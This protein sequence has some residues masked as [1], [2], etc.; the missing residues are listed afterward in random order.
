MGLH[1]RYTRVFFLSFY[2]PEKITYSNTVKSTSKLRR[3]I[4]FIFYHYTRKLTFYTN[5]QK[6]I[7]SRFN[8]NDFLTFI[9]SYN[10][11]PIKSNFSMHAVV[12]SI[13][14][15]IVSSIITCLLILFMLMKSTCLNEIDF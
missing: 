2:H 3:T 8:E 11:H 12:K 14:F 4:K 7:I 15:I 1:Q 6:K 10:K 13:S 9:F 5:V